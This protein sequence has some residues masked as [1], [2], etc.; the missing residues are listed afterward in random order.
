[1]VEI[2]GPGPNRFRIERVLNI[3]GIGEHLAVP[4]LPHHRAYGSVPRR[5]GGLS[6]SQ[7]L[8]GETAEALEVSFGESLVEGCPGAPPPGSFRREHGHTGRPLAS[9]KAAK[10]CVAS[11]T[12]LPL[13]PDG[14]SQ[15]P[16]DPAIKGC[17]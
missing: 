17:Q 4:P 1:M 16:P 14:A 2:G 6:K 8:H 12:R 13:D 7:L 11:D 5:F 3:I 10:L 15:S 9:P